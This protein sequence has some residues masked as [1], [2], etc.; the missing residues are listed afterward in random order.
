MIKATLEDKKYVADILTAAF[1][2]NQSVNS[3]IQQGRRE[4]RIK[5]LM[6]YSFDVCSAFGAVYLSDDRQACAL[7]VFP[8]QKQTTL[9]S[10][11]WDLKLVFT[12]T[13]F[14]KIN[15]ILGR[16]ARIK[17]LHPTEPFYHLWY[18]GVNPQRQNEGIGRKLLEEIIH[19]AQSENRSV[20][21]ETSM[22]KNIP[23]Y[24]KSGFELFAEQ[25]FGYT[26]YFFRTKAPESEK[27][28]L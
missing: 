8:D 27:V 15:Y 25:D 4:Y 17:A 2:N 20:Y 3:I 11:L 24:Q 10:L 5:R 13:G 6:E 19:K 26:L 18:I 28:V 16:E 23:W 21:L 12:C 22:L 9:R 1:E 14:R 7:V